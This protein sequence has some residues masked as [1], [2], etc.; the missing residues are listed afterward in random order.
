MTII[1]NLAVVSYVSEND[2]LEHIIIIMTGNQLEDTSGRI[3][4]KYS[5]VSGK[6]Q[7]RSVKIFF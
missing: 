2:F 6:V 7:M 1:L 3:G 4:K 5:N